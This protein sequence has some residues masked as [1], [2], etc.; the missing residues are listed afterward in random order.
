M[1]NHFDVASRIIPTKTPSALAAE[2]VAPEQ[3][4][5]FD[6]LPAAPAHH[7]LYVVTRRGGIGKGATIHLH[8]T[9]SPG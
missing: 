9:P 6:T 4:S 5:L 7:E 2:P 1:A 8:N 3:L